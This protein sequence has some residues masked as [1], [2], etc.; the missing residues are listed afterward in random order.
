MSFPSN[1]SPARRVLCFRL[2]MLTSLL[3]RT[4]R[5]APTPIRMLSSSPSSVR[6]PL[7]GICWD[8]DGTLT[9][10]NLDFKVMYERC[11]VPITEDILVSVSK[12]SPNER[13][14]A[15]RII[16]EMEEEGR[17]TLALQPGAAELM[18]FLPI[19][20]F[21]WLSSPETPAAR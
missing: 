20:A 13:A 14:E 18:R 3:V 11:G 8:M 17:K 5:N 2:C 21:R 15:E 9:V 10:P 4:Y 1:F 16:E 6:P 12:M 19:N 7:L